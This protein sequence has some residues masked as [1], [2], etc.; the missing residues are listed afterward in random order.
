MNI[1]SWK[2]VRFKEVVELKQGLAFNSKNNHILAKKGIPLLRIVDLNNNSETKFVNPKLVSDQFISKT[3][4]IIYSRTGILLGLVYTN[5]VGVVHN[6][7]FRI[8]PNEEIY[9]PYLFWYLKQNSII[10]HARSIAGGTAQPDLNHDAFKS[11]FFRYPNIE[12][13]KKIANTLSAYDDLIEN[14]NQRIQLLEEMAAEIYKEWFVRFRFPGYESATFVDKEGKEVPHGT[15]GALPL[16]W[17]RVKFR[18]CLSH[19]IGGGWGKEKSTGKSEKLAHVIRGTDIPNLRKGK[20]NYDV[21]RFHTESN[22]STRRCIP[23]D[24]IFEVSGGTEEQSLGRT[25]FIT[26]G[27]LD[28]FED[29]VIGASFCKLLRIN[30]NLVSPFYINAFLSRMYSTGELKVF[31]VQS[32]GIS[33]YQFEDFIDYTKVLKPIKSITEQFD[34]MVSA[35][36]DEIQILGAKNETLQQTRDLLLPRLISGKLSVENLAL[37]KEEASL[38]QN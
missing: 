6:N 38:V 27:I 16:G 31:Q 20:L 19:Y 35:M 24:I 22:L 23:N 2:I 26:Q 37:P 34:K 30:E 13:Q 36:L 4:D 17:E 21:L 32:T 9:P 10:K 15:D 33:N 5:R 25:I 3:S 7:C 29:D 14:N 12:T 8:I 1:D 28:R 11:I 18:D